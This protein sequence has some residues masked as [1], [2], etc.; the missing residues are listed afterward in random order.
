VIAK[1]TEEV[2]IEEIA[3]PVEM[4]GSQNV[5]VLI[6]SEIETEEEVT[7]KTE[8]IKGIET[9]MSQVVVVP[10]QKAVILRLLDRSQLL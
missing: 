1:K 2:E 7:A 5:G 6:G 8:M 10:L 3:I 9:G 4:K